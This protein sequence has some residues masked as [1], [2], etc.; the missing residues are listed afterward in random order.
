[1]KYD[2]VA[3]IEYAKKYALSPNKSYTFIDPKNDGIGDDC[4]N[5]VSQCLYAG[6]CSMV[7][8]PSPWFY[9]KL[10]FSP[11]YNA[12]FSWSVAHSLYWFL[13][14]NEEN[15]GYGAKGLETKDIS[16]L[17]VGDLIFF[18]RLDNHIFHVSIITDFSPTGEPLISQH[19][20]NKLNTPIRPDYYKLHIH[21]IKITL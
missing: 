3:A 21:Y 13:K 19:S 7:Y 10:N 14:T 16:S 15:N 5:F 4:T 12:S 1:M 9:K 8:S 17:K 2:N 18:G 6:G 20:Y 11:Y